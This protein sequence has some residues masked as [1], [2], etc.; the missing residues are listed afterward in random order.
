M[1]LTQNPNYIS[2]KEK[3]SLHLCEKLFLVLH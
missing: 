1:T 3:V 2:K